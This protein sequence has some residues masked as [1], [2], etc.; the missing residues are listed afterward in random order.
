MLSL[1][2][3]Y[4]V[5]LLGTVL[6]PSSLISNASSLSLAMAETLSETTPSEKAQPATR[7]LFLGDSLTAGYGLEQSMAYPAILRNMASTQGI[8]LEIINAGMSGDTSAGALRRLP[9]LLKNKIELCFV[10]IG[11]N[12]GL[13]GLSLQ[14]FKSNLSKIVDTVRATDPQIKIILAGMK[15]PENFGEPYRSDFEKVYLEVSKEKNLPLIPFL[16]EGVAARPELTLEDRLHP[17]EQGQQ[18][19]AE[20]IWPRVKNIILSD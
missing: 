11:A 9:W 20:H 2:L 19:I 14:S 16:L 10:A 18:V 5:L 6:I 8:R 1:R 3:F 4:L 17:S 7:I 13:R 15:L 12:D